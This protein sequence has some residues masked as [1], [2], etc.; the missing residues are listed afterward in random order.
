MTQKQTT[1][2]KD[3]VKEELWRRGVLLW[4]LD[5][6]QKILYKLFHESSHKLM[7]WLLA[8]R[9]G[10]TFCIA[11][12]AIEMCIKQKNNI[13]KIVAPTKLQINTILRPIFRKILE[14]CP[15][16]LVPKYDGKQYIYFFSNGSEIQLAGTDSGHAE[17]L[18]GG[19]SHAWFIDEA[20]TCDDLD[21]IV[22]SILMPTTLTT[23]GK[24]VLSGTPPK[25]T[26]HDFVKF[27]ETAD[28][29]GSLVIKTIDDNPRVTKEMREE[30]IQEVG[31][32]HTIDAQ[33]ELY[34]KIVKDASSSVIPEFDDNLE[35]EI[36]K[37]WPKPP[38]YDCYVSMDLGFNDL[39]V[40]LFMYY[41]FRA[42]KVIV[43]DEIVMNGEQMHLPILTKMIEDIEQKHW[44]NTL[45]NEQ[46]K[47]YVRL[48]DIDYI[49]M[50]EIY[51][52]SQGRVSFIATKKDDK[53]AAIQTL[54]TAL[55]AKKIIINPNCKTLIRHLKNAK[56]YSEN[57]KSKFS[58]SPDDGHYDAVDALL[59]GF[60]G[61]A[62][63]KNP[64]PPGYDYNMRDLYIPKNSNFNRQNDLDIFKKIFNVK[65]K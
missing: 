36:V 30:L 20:G 27:I 12:I 4:K 60:R 7:T 64:Y 18:R 39:T 46:R 57:N 32:L 65:R 52:A 55:A 5:T 51:K 59:Y 24:G 31:G 58:R 2:S 48:S 63:G 47:P 40:V 41:D 54:R 16:D 61:I 42:D 9:S 6:N 38:F 37:E 17:K 29:R 21:N 56:W 11:V 53:N 50:N 13:V 15:E 62:Y 8:R 44:Y 25:N 23:R 3:L 43:E 22:K 1:L 19:D 28:M 35:K 45:T 34:C 14:D 26:D 49:A 10:K 33:R